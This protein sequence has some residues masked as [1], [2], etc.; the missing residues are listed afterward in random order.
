MKRS[1][2]FTSVSFALLL[3]SGCGG[4]GTAPTLQSNTAVVFSA[5]PSGNLTT[6]ISGIQITATLP[7]G[8]FLNT[9]S[10]RSLRLGENGLK[11]LK[12]NAQ[13]FGRYSATTNQVVFAL[14][15]NPIT[16]DMGTGDFARLTYTTSTGISLSETSFQNISHKISG[17]SSVDLSSQVTVAAKLTRY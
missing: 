14:V 16:S 2:L 1:T 12:G 8:V 5:T 11:S 4:G 3:L 15:A 13:I 10:G 9:S 6:A 7:Q 17:P